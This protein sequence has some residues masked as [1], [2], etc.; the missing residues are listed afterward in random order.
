MPM[1]LGDVSGCY[2]AKATLMVNTLPLPSPI[3]LLSS[4]RQR[5]ENIQRKYFSLRM[6]T[7]GIEVEGIL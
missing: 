4:S 6:R 3:L 1:I 2:A 7:Y 5:R